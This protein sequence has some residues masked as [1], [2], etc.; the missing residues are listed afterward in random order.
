MSDSSK[1]PVVT[2]TGLI[3]G[4]L[5][6]TLPFLADVIIFGGSGQAGKI[7]DDPGPVIG[8]AAY[9]ASVFWLLDSAMRPRPRVERALWIGLIMTSLIWLTFALTGRTYQINESLGN[10][11]IGLYILLMAW[12]LIC[13]ILMGIIAK[14]GEVEHDA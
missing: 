6:L 8:F 12:P 3:T 5:A 9:T 14:F 11:N 13:T 1:R 10:A 2:R 7:L 4:L